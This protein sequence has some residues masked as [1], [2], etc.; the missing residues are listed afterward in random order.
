MK[1]IFLFII[2]ISILVANGAGQEKLRIKVPLKYEVRD[3]PS[4]GSFH[5]YD[6][7]VTELSNGVN[8]L[9]LRDKPLIAFITPFENDTTKK[10]VGRYRRRS[11]VG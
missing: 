2:L 5:T 6:K 4:I 3:K 7:D 8:V 10:N 11:A 1:K 9:K